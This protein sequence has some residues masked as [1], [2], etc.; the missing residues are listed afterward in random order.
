VG[1]PLSCI[2]TSMGLAVALE[3]ELPPRLRGDRWHRA[4]ELVRIR[5]KM[6][7]KGLIGFSLIFVKSIWSSLHACLTWACRVCVAS[8]PPHGRRIDLLPS[9]TPGASVGSSPFSFVLLLEIDADSPRQTPE[10]NIAKGWRFAPERA[11]HPAGSGGRKPWAGVRGWADPSR[12][13]A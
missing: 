5:T 4:K 3:A 10:R 6:P 13:V 2:M 7:G 11:S 9:P 12:Q 8:V 1:E